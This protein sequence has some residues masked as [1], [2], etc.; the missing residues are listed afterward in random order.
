[1]DTI[2]Q[3]LNL[4]LLAMYALSFS[5]VVF[6]VLNIIWIKTTSPTLRIVIIIRA[7][8]P[9]LIL[10]AVA[11]VVGLFP[12]VRILDLTIVVSSFSLSL[13]SLLCKQ[14]IS[15]HTIQ[16]NILQGIGA[17]VIF[18]NFLFL[19]SIVYGAMTICGSGC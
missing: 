16:K 19:G 14:K 10:S 11:R 5:G 4:E 2:F 13:I 12:W 1:M 7:L 18:L 17:W 9:F 15:I 3:N 6:S 8:S